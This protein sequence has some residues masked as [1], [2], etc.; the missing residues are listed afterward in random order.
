MATYHTT[1]DASGGGNGTYADPWTLQEAADSAIA[2]DV[3]KVHNTGTYSLSSA[4]DFDTHSGSRS[5]PISFIG[6][7][8]AEAD[9]P[10]MAFI[11]QTASGADGFNVI[12]SHLYFESLSL[13]GASSADGWSVGGDHVTCV[14]CRAHGAGQAG[15]LGQTADHLTLV[16]CE[17]HSNGR[18][19]VS[20]GG[21]SLHRATLLGCAAHN[22][23]WAGIHLERATALLWRCASY[24]NS[25]G[26]RVQELEAD[27]G[28]VVLGCTLLDN[29]SDGIEVADINADAALLV[30]NCIG[31]R[32]GAYGM[33][34][35]SAVHAVLF[36]NLWP[37]SGDDANTAG[38]TN[39]IVV[40]GNPDDVLKPNLDAGQVAAFVDPT[41]C[42]PD[43]RL[44]AGSDAM[45]A[46]WPGCLPI[47]DLCTTT[48]AAPTTTTSGA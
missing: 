48:T 22:N 27:A 38:N 25:H 37:S 15:L 20:L 43:L 36:G 7:G 45:G 33:D 32:N 35:A 47:T 5:S 31:V 42:Y 11:A 21:G 10:E 12:Q 44:G 24:G 29:G 28:V 39:N 19:G 13:Q 34:A 2:G 23:A 40:L 26:V 6:V 9:S 3:V 46:A 1:H 17:F 8:P 4:L 30:A 16:G 14:R 18:Q 41:V